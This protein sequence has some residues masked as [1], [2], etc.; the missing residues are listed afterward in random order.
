MEAQ[1]AFEHCSGCFGG[2]SEKNA[3]FSEVYL[4][5]TD[6]KQEDLSP[7]SHP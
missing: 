5:Q 2:C 1:R 7:T 4:T 3:Q 6:I